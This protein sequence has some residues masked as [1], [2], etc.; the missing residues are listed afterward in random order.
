MYNTRYFLSILAA[1]F[2]LNACDNAADKPMDLSAH[3][4]II[5]QEKSLVEQYELIEDLQESAAEQT[6]D[7]IERF[8][9]MGAQDSTLLATLLGH[10][11]RLAD[12]AG[13]LQKHQLI[14]EQH[15]DL[16]EL[17]EETP[18]SAT[19]INTQHAVMKK[20]FNEIGRELST[21]KFEIEKIKTEQE[22]FRE[23]LAMQ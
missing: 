23:M 15:E 17:H 20:N 16:Q 7:M 11:T 19:E 22:A 8:R 10:E 1:L 2:L 9:E 13:K 3:Q 18:L 12:H 4:Q 14:F 5:E 6:D 21:I